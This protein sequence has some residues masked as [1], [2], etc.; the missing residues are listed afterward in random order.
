LHSFLRCEENEIQLEQQRNSFEA[1]N[2]E[3]KEKLISTQ[4]QLRTLGME[5]SQLQQQ[6][7]DISQV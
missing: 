2:K 4:H 6:L 7:Q 5:N 1:L 3:L